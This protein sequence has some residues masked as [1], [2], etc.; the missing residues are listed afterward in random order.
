[1]KGLH[2]K[3]LSFGPGFS[4]KN[5]ELLMLNQCFDKR[6]KD[7]SQHGATDAKLIVYITTCAT[8][9]TWSSTDCSL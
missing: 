6:N 4:D 7:K 1:M 5:T 8:R 2:L 9:G 3:V